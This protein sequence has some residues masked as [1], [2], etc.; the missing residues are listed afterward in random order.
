[1]K[2][3][4]YIEIK[5]LTI[6]EN[7][8][9][10]VNK[11]LLPGTGISN[12]DFWNGFNKN[13]HELASKNKELLEKREE[14]QK[15]IDDFHKKRKGNEFNFKEY[16]KFLNDIGYLKK[17]G[18]DFKIKTKNVDIEIAKICGPQLVVPIMNA[19]YAINATNARWV[20]LYDSLYGTDI[21]SE[22]KGAVRGKTYNPIRG[23]KV[24]EYARNLLDKYVPLKK[25]SWKDIS[26]IPQVNN[27][28]LNLKLKNPKQFVGYVKKSNN[29]SSLLLINNNLHIDIIFD[30]DGTLEINNPE[31]NQDRA[32]MHDIFL[33]CRKTPT[34]ALQFIMMK[35]I[36]LAVWIKVFVDVVSAASEE[37]EETPQQQIERL[38]AENADLKTENHY[39]RGLAFN[40]AHSARSGI[41]DEMVQLRHDVEQQKHEMVRLER[42]W[43]QCN[44]KKDNEIQIISDRKPIP[45]PL[46]PVPLP[47]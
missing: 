37:F 43:R 16:N 41:D 32:A 27:N 8:Y 24:I 25:G 17:V 21:I 33:E 14:L 11:N 15:K 31:G 38:A 35:S 20:S 34:E 4:Q 46:V 29:L 47:P 7:L 30:L 22:T 23:K 13:I 40:A 26:E 19:R 5:K 42:G 18:P 28:K 1:M 3:E 45:I 6:S 9:S 12:S 10:F 39:I 2:K 36:L 44:A